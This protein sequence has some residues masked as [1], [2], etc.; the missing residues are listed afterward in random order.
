M[1]FKPFVYLY[2]PLH[3]L[4]SGTL[5]KTFSITSLIPR[6]L[7]IRALSFASLFFVLFFLWRWV[8]REESIS[9]PAFAL[10]LV[11]GLSKFTDYATSAR[12]DTF[13]LIFEL[14]ALAVFVSWL[15]KPHLKK[16][17]FFS[18]LVLLSFMTRQTGIGAIASVSVWFLWKRDFRFLFTWMLPTGLLLLIS[19]ALA[20]HLTEGAY[21]QQVFLANVRGW[22]PVDKYFFDPSLLSFLA[23]YALFGVLTIKGLQRTQ[24]E[25]TKFLGVALGTTLLI[26]SSLFFRAGGDVNYFFESILIALGFCALALQQDWITTLKPIKLATLSAQIAVIVFVCGYKTISATKLAFLPYAEMAQEVKTRLPKFVFVTGQLGP[27]FGL[28]L[29]EWGIH[30][31]DV[32]NWSRVAKNGHKNVRWILRDLED[33]M[34][35]GG[36]S[37]VVMAGTECHN[38]RKRF[39]PTLPMKNRYFRRMKK[40]EWLADWLCLY[41][42]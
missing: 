27:G 14:G 13:W 16:M 23:S 6:V 26:S 24:N 42:K 4:V 37:G 17:I 7:F 33:T 2:P 15:K 10:A 8:F 1:C 5:L 41:H 36:V 34:E 30:G 21:F 9:K 38:K 32:T 18:F 11:L 12:N 40:K 25:S 20:N 19:L 31:P 28:Y 35:A 3:G 39:V 29:R 22:R